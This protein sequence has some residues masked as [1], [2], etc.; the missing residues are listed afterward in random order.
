MLSSTSSITVFE[1]LDCPVGVELRVCLPHGVQY[2]T[3][4]GIDSSTTPNFSLNTVWFCCCVRCKS[5]YGS[6]AEAVKQAREVKILHV[7]YYYYS[8]DKGS[9]SYL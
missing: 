5:G 3:L 6:L 4:Y 1:E 8:M 9:S 7:S 2:Q